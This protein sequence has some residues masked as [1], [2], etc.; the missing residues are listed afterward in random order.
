MPNSC[1]LLLDDIGK[2]RAAYVRAALFELWLP[3]L[4][5]PTSFCR[6]PARDL[7]SCDLATPQRHMGDAAAEE[8]AALDDAK[9]RC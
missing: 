2:L 8:K 3:C 9:L 6:L 4:L 5:W 7:D 1:V